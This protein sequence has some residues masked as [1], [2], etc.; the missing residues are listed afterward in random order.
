LS[1]VGI[2]NRSLWSRLR[3][4]ICVSRVLSTTLAACFLLCAADGRRDWHLFPAVAHTDANEDVYVV[5]DVHADYGRL[6]RVLEAAAVIEKNPP[7][8]KHPAWKAG[9]AVVVFMG[10][11]IDKGPRALDVLDFVQA[12]R[13][14]ANEKGGRVFSVMGNHEAEFLAHPA[15]KKG[16]EFVDELN[17]RG[18][19]PADVA[20]CKGEVGEFLCSEPFALRVRSWFFC[21]AGNT[22]GRTMSKLIS[23]LQAGVDADGFGTPELI[24]DDS[25]LEAR[26][27]KQGPHGRPWFESGPQHDAQS[28]L[29]AY[30]AALGVK[31]IVQGHQHAGFAF[32]DGVQRKKGQMFQRYGL[33][34]LVDTGMSEGVGDSEGAVLLIRAEP[35]EEAI[36]I[37]PDGARKVIWDSTFMPTVGS[38]KACGK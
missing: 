33:I 4:E 18:P 22:H 26:V 11:L 5:G 7:D 6:I 32:A 17:T 28:L 36:A 2:Y 21:H 30:A 37:C 14:A 13:N 31:H 20:S 15:A 16:Q 34:F 19:A 8:P 23:D 35:R 24:G 12:L 9:H 27:G 25:I 3:I 38:A 29:R 1:R 10:D